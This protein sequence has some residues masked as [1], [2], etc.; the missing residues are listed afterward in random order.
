[1]GFA[2]NRRLKLSPPAGNPL[3]IN[4]N[5]SSAGFSAQMETGGERF[6]LSF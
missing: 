6:L 4:Y 5:L 3:E 1:M 2:T